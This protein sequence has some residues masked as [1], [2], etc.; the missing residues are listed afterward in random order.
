MTNFTHAK[1]GP[2]TVRIDDPTYVVPLLTE[3]VTVGTGLAFPAADTVAIEAGGVEKARFTSTLNSLAGVTMLLANSVS[4]AL[5]VTQT[6]AGNAFVVED[7]ASTDSTPFVINS[8]C[9]CLTV[10]WVTMP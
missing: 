2:D 3:D 6:G 10:H 8:N 1:Y 9:A 5:I 4:A 7:S